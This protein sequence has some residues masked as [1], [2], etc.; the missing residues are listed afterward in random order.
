MP[1]GSIGNDAAAGRAIQKALLH[2][3]GL[4]YVFYGIDGL[5]DGSCNRIE[6]DGAAAEFLNDDLQNLAVRPIEAARIDFQSIEGMIGKVSRNRLDIGD[7]GKVTD[8]LQ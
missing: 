3:E 8:P 6:A 2:Q 7:L 5:A 1:I 4:V